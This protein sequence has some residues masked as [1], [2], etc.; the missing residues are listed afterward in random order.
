MDKIRVEYLKC[1]TE[2]MKSLIEAKANEEQTRFYYIL[3]T[4]LP[5]IHDFLWNGLEDEE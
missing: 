1:Q 2:Y 4:Y 5:E 3:W